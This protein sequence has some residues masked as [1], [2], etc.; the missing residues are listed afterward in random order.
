MPAREIR[1]LAG[2][3]AVIGKPGAVSPICSPGGMGKSRVA[4]ASA[5]CP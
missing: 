1:A 3:V 5:A 4:W 2:N